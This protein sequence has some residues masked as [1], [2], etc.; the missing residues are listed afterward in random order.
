MPNAEGPPNEGAF[1]FHPD[2]A[3]EEL[4]EILRAHEYIALNQQLRRRR[5]PAEWTGPFIVSIHRVLFGEVF[6]E[7]SGIP[8]LG[9]ILFGARHGVEPESIYD[10]LRAI[11]DQFRTDLA[12]ALTLAR[13]LDELLDHVFLSAALTHAEMIRVHPFVDGNGRWARF[14]TNLYIFDCGLPVGTIVLAKDKKRYIEAMN[15]ASDNGEPGDLANI[16]LEGFLHQANRQRAGK[17][18]R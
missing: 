12:K 9:A 4:R 7:L 2:H 1:D 6:P 10:C 17:P 14:L 13:E 15:R 3:A 5:V 18:R 11:S 8:R 16:L